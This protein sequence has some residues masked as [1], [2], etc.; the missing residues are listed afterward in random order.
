MMGHSLT[1]ESGSAK[2]GVL[3]ARR[4]GRV[5]PLLVQAGISTTEAGAAAEARRAVERLRVIAT[6]Y[7]RNGCD[8]ELDALLLPLDEVRLAGLSIEPTAEIMVAVEAA[9][10]GDEAP[11]ARWSMTKHVDDARTYLVATNKA[12]I[13]LFSGRRA[14]YTKH[15]ELSR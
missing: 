15:P 4:D 3:R 14:V 10:A 2:S 5:A 12:I 1:P 6:E 13:A 8:S 7:V 9:D 11:R